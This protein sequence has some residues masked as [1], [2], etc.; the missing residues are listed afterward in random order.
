MKAILIRVKKH[1]AS[2]YKNSRV[3]VMILI[4]LV[5]VT[6]EN[7][8]LL[9]DNLQNKTTILGL[10]FENT[11]ISFFSRKKIEA[12]ITHE[13][14]VKN[15]PMTFVLG[16]KSYQMFPRDIAY[17][18][19]APYLT[20]QLLQIGR[21]GTVLQKLLTQEKALFGFEDKSVTGTYSQSLL[22]LQ[23]SQM[24]SVFDQNPQVESLDVSH[25]FM[26][27][28]AK[29]GVKIQLDKLT[30]IILHGIA[31]PPNDSITV[32]TY[33]AFAT[34]HSPSELSPIKDQI[35]QLLI[36]PISLSANNQ[37]LTLTRND[38]GNMLTV[39]ER[40]DPFHP[41]KTVLRLHFDDKK[42]S[43]KLGLFAAPIEL[44][45]NSEFNDEDAKVAIIS[46]FF[47]GNRQL[48]TIPTGQNFIQKRVLGA[49]T[50]QSMASPKVAYLTFDDGPNNIYH[51][52]ILD[53][54]K[55]FNIKATFFLIGQN[56]KQYPDIVKQTVADGHLIGNHSLTHSF[57]PNL[58]STSQLSELQ[59]TNAILG[60]NQPITLFRPP[61]GGI[62]YTVR[63]NAHTLGLKIFLW[64]VDPQDWSEPATD[65]LVRR[66][67]SAVHDGSN[68]LLHSNHLVTV[69]ALPRIISTLQSEGYSFKRLDQYPQ[70]EED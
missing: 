8:V 66:V 14:S 43:E 58:T 64:D 15:R 28:P 35:S 60:I 9:Y 29:D 40:P 42:L 45:T 56:A 54:L 48:I 3:R 18:V 41:G 65:E 11:N 61:Y 39:V 27:I 12:L 59:T 53:I 36:S 2:Y 13:A 51:P 19:D 5:A 52:M 31:S 4:L 26:T 70:A 55:T 10:K 33:V 30:S 22:L 46:E 7:G 63:L 32:P 67:T 38:L 16:Q 69:R 44:Q 50:K 57:M 20:N 24:Q 6:L 62:N 47:S 17:K 49:S 37:V 25:N 21:T 68:I 23:V 1:I 34:R